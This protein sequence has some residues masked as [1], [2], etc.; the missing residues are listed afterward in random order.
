[1]YQKFEKRK[2]KEVRDLRF[3]IQPYEWIDPIYFNKDYLENLDIW[4]DLT[5]DSL[6][7]K[8][9]NSFKNRSAKQYTQ[10]L[11]NSIFNCICTY[12]IFSKINENYIT[13]FRK[14]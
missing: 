4:V 12:L 2:G 10:A 11:F 7:S 13:I 9:T 6:T 14:L 3:L 1:M 5:K 8:L